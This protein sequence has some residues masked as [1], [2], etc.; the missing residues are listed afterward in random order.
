MAGQTT[1]AVNMSLI[2]TASSVLI[3]LLSVLWLRERLSTLQ[4]VGIA[5]ALA[6]VVHVAIQGRWASLAS[7]VWVAGDA[8]TLAAATAWAVFSVLLRRWHSPLSVT[9]LGGHQRC[10]LPVDCAFCRARTVAGAGGRPFDAE[11]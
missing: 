4:S 8:W 6:G 9:A 11:L 10:R 3:A 7:V 2:S 5:I 1:S